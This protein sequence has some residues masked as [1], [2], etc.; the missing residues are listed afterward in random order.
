MQFCRFMHWVGLFQSSKNPR[1][2]SENGGKE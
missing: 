2:K 1:G